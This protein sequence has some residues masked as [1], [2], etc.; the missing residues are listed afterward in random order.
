MAHEL[1]ATDAALGQHPDCPYLLVR[2]AI[3]IQTQDNGHDGYT[4]EDAERCLLRA[5]QLDDTYLEAIEELAHFYHAVKVNVAEAKR[6]AQRYLDRV[7]PIGEELR[8][9]LRDE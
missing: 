7:G 1:S 8:E 9:I 5:H 3:L 6:F 4:L 2:K